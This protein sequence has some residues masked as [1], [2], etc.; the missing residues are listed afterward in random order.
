MAIDT[1]SELFP[2]Q[3]WSWIWV[4]IY[5]GYSLDS[6]TLSS[7]YPHNYLDKLQANKKIWIYGGGTVGK[8]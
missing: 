8:Q 6:H 1:L 5:L 2:C 4:W 3:N 7:L